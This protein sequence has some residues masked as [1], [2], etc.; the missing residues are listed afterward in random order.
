MLQP[1]V[2]VLEQKEPVQP[3]ELPLQELQA[4]QPLAF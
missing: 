1:D 3:D 4:W 2:Q